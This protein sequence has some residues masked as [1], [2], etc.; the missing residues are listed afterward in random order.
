MFSTY[1]QLGFHHISDL[2]AYDHM[3]F[4]LALCLGY[5]IK[6]WKQLGWLVTAFTIGHSITLAMSVLNVFVANMAIIEFL[7]PVTILCTAIS[8]MVFKNAANNRLKY[9]ITLGFGCIHGMGFSNFLKMTLGEEENLLVPL[10]SFN[11]GLELGQLI[12][13][14][15]IILSIYVINKFLIKSERDIALFLNGGVCFMALQLMMQTKFW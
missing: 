2:G 9:A 3:L 5:S 4:I 14:A 8:N 13:L 6:D 7:I 1:L 12:I 15:C 10:L 11:I